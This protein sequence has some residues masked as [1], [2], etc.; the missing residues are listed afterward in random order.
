[1]NTSTFYSI[2]TKIIVASVHNIVSSDFLKMAK[3]EGRALGAEIIG[4]NYQLNQQMFDKSLVIWA[5]TFTFYLTRCISATLVT[6]AISN[7][8][9]KSQIKTIN[10]IAVFFNILIIPRVLSIITPY[11]GHFA[12]TDNNRKYLGKV[13]NVATLVTSIAI[14]PSMLSCSLT[15]G[16]GAFTLASFTCIGVGM[17][18]VALFKS[19]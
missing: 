12:D 2:S 5:K 3:S 9:L 8:V 17:D 6:S 15:I 16:P 18:A 10:Y 13:L 14:L 7:S 19:L 4:N 11:T 1:M